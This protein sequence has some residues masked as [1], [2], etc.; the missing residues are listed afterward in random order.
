MISLDVQKGDEVE[1]GGRLG[2]LKTDEDG[3]TEIHFEIWKG[4]E[5]QNPSL[6][7]KKR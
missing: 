2:T 7:L 6:W 1:V 4:S 3:K 5:K